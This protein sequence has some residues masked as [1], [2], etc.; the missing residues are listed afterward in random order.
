MRDSLLLHPDLEQHSV[1]HSRRDVKFVLAERK[2]TSYVYAPALGGSLHN[3]CQEA[4][5]GARHPNGCQKAPQGRQG[6][7][8]GARRPSRSLR[9]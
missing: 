7:P 4:L 6:P 3:C 8:T 9:A 2:L 1:G 5:R